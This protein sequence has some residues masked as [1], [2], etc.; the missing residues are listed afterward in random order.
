MILAPDQT[1]AGRK[2]I[3]LKITQRFPIFN[4]DQKSALIREDGSILDTSEYR[5]LSMPPDLRVHLTKAK[6]NTGKDRLFLVREPQIS[7]EGNLNDQHLHVLT[8]IS[9]PIIKGLD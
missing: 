1:G 9:A 2:V 3:D 7:Q 5:H 4:L 6:T 8:F